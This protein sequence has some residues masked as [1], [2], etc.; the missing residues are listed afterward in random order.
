[1][2]R[3][4]SLFAGAAL[5]PGMLS[6][7]PMVE[8]FTSQG[9]YSC[10]PADEHLAELIEKNPEVVAL[11]FHVDYWDD[12][13]YGSAGVWKDPF[14]DAAYTKRQRAYNQ[15]DLKGKRGVYTPQMIVN[16]ATAQVGTRR[17]A[18]KKA[19]NYEQPSLKMT[20]RTEG[21][22]VEV[23]ISGEYDAKALVW[24]AV[25]DK[26]Q[27]TEVTTGENHGKR[28]INHH[29]VRELTPIADWRNGGGATTVDVPSLQDDNVGCAIFVQ[30][31][32]IGK[33]LGAEYC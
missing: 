5:L 9:C 26:Y 29:V 30:E 27:S 12:L 23:N 7:A 33:V 3:I 15:L 32:K 20:T 24:L 6:A 31:T 10:P 22:Q 4:L 25:F 17:S 13:V 8:L 11:E 28:M 19:L 16:G 14:S 1:M 2:P 18:V 21:T